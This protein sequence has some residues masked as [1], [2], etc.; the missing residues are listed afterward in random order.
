MKKT[1]WIATRTTRPPYHL[2]TNDNGNHHMDCN[3]SEQTTLSPSL[4]GLILASTLV[5]FNGWHL[6]RGEPLHQH[7]LTLTLL[8]CLDRWHLSRG[9]SLDQ[10]ADRRHSS[11]WP[12]GGWELVMWRSILVIVFVLALS[13]G[14]WGRYLICVWEAQCCWAI[15]INVGVIQIDGKNSDELRSDTVTDLQTP[16][17]MN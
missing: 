12:P 6:S 14:V 7:L 1:T 9:G 13:T 15:K 5:C 4:P 2:L 17:L 11:I 8:T 16:A 10:H 3:N